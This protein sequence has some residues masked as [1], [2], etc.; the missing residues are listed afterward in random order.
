MDCLKII[1]FFGKTLKF[2]GVNPRN[3]SLMTGFYEL[4]EIVQGLARV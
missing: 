4:V 3:W 2:F 1:R